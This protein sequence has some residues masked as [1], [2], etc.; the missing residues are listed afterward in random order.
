MFR[1]EKEMW[2]RKYKDYNNYI[3]SSTYNALFTIFS[4][5]FSL[6]LFKVPVKNGMTIVIFK[7]INIKNERRVNK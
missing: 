6:I 3:E 1:N 2:R 4:L 5:K 7:I